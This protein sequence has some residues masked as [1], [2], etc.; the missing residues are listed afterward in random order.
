VQPAFLEQSARI[1]KGGGVMHV[2][3]DWANYAEHTVA[4]FGGSAWFEPI[5]PETLSG[6][7][8]ESRPPTKFERRGRRLGHEVVDLHF[9]RLP[10]SRGDE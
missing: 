1:L 10:I 2:A 6:S 9:R 8:L 3:T 5:R 7:A 4:T